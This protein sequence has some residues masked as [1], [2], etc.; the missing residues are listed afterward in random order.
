VAVQVRLASG[1]DLE[2]GGG[3]FDTRDASSASLFKKLDENVVE[4]EFAPLEA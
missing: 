3:R 1:D 4:E 2:S